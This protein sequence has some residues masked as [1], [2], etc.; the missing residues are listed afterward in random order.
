MQTFS[1]EIFNCSMA[2]RTFP[3]EVSHQTVSSL[4]EVLTDHF[5]L[6]TNFHSLK[7]ESTTKLKQCEIIELFDRI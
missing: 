5:C 2:H 3:L 1:V 4:D 7:L 6:K